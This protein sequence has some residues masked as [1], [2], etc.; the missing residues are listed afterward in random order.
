M[1]GPEPEL[2][3]LIL[4]TGDGLRWVPAVARGRRCRDECRAG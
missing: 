4:Y 1:A 2:K 3:R